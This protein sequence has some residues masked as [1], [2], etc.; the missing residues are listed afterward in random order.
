M[1]VGGQKSGLPENRY[2][3]KSASNKENIGK[4]LFE[5]GRLGKYISVWH[6]YYRRSEMETDNFVKGSAIDICA[7]GGSNV[8]MLWVRRCEKAGSAEVC[9]LCASYPDV[10]GVYKRAFLSAT[11]SDHY[12]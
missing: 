4:C 6:D 11:L 10:T 1:T 3:W 2:Q 9:E 12:C 8:W 5:T 7:R